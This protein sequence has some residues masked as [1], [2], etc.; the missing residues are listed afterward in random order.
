MRS[1]GLLVLGPVVV[2]A[3]SVVVVLPNIKAPAARRVIIGPAST[4]VTGASV[5]IGELKRVG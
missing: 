3:N 2:A 1:C 4:P 5:Y